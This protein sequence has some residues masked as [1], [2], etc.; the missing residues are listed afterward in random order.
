MA[1]SVAAFL[2]LPFIPDY[3]DTASMGTLGQQRVYLWAVCA[4]LLAVTIFLLGMRGKGVWFGA[5]LNRE[6][7]LDLARL[8]LVVW[9]IIL[10][11]AIHIALF[12]NLLTSGEL[13]LTIP[14][15]VWVLL[16]IDIATLTSTSIILGTKR[17]APPPTQR[18]SARH[19]VLVINDGHGGQN[20]V[21]NDGGT[22][23]I[24]VLVARTD[25]RDWSWSD[26]FLGS[27]LGNQRSADVGKVQMF[28]FSAIMFTAYATLLIQTF[29]DTSAPLDALP[30]FSASILT[31]IAISHAGYLT[32]LAVRHTDTG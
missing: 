9:T 2:T 30:G 17:E 26:L 20:H 14:T 13:T 5:L 1:M 32:N 29:Q 4:L 15:E 7:R 3:F 27:E 18:E 11:P 19:G 25:P 31:A 6:N 22:E 10:L 28:F 16:T 24:G 12:G 21:M 8:Q 23:V